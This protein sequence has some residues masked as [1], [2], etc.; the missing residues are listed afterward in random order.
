[1][2]WRVSFFFSGEHCGGAHCGEEGD[3]ARIFS[4]FF[5]FV[6][7]IVHFSG[8]SVGEVGQGTQFF[9]LCFSTLS[10]LFMFTGVSI[11]S[12]YSSSM[13]LFPFF[14]VFYGGDKG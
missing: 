2:F 14:L 7:L 13:V 6:F 11:Y 12:G 3:F 5:S 1:M 4:G 10:L 9:C 8:F